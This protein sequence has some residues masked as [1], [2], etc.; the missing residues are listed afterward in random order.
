MALYTIAAATPQNTPSLTRVFLDGG[1]TTLVEQSVGPVGQLNLG[2]AA[3]GTLSLTSLGSV[4]VAGDFT[5]SAAGML[6]LEL[7][8]GSHAA[9]DVLGTAQ[10]AGPLVV[11]L[12]PLFAPG[13]G[14][15]F[16]LLSA[17]SVTGEFSS[18]LLPELNPGLVWK[19]A[20]DPSAVVLSVL[21]SADFN[22][23][24]RVDPLDLAQ[25]QAGY[26]MSSAGQG[27]GDADGDGDVDGADFLVWQRQ[28]G[29]VA[30]VS[31]LGQ[32]PEPSAVFLALLAG[33][34][35]VCSRFGWP[36]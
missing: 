10:L 25:W 29:S 36:R 21:F 20:Y 2:G 7:A 19:L 14:Q 8:A 26:A 30:A 13:A 3:A 1:G 5:Q 28:F 24:G 23:D 34:I 9:L 15:A 16:E 4:N 27:D 35:V 18:A 31:S 11:S 12:D 32:I 17:G 22:A 33:P 6:A